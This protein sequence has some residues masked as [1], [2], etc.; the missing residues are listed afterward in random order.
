MQKVKGNTIFARR[1]LALSGCAA[2]A[3]LMFFAGIPAALCFSVPEQLHYDL[4]W[5]GIKTG[6]A[7]L[8]VRKE[9]G[10]VQ[11]ISKANSAKWVSVFHRVDDLVVSTLRREHAVGFY[12]GFVGDP[13][14]YRI[15]L[16]EGK[17]RRDK[18]VILDHA[19]KKATYINH[20]SGERLSFAISESAMDPLSCF[21]YIR[22]LP[23]EVGRSVYVDVFDNKKSYRAEVQVLKKEV[24]ET[25]L[26]AFN[27]ILIK[28]LIRSEGIFYRRGD[29][30]IWLTDDKRRVPVQLKTKVALGS[31][32]AVL[33]GGRY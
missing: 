17:Y 32:R 29:L 28:P 11:F 15:K 1:G 4:T 7:V 20:I 22:T 33:A 26:G 14:N 24:V 2:I 6:E 10:N 25:P 27:T 3:L 16:R 9:A 13:F 8:E 18:E 5:A 23:L 31:V 12:G 30:Y 19:A 21:Y